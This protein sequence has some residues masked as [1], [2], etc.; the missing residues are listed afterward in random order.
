VSDKVS[1][2]ILTGA[3]FAVYVLA[4]ASCAAA[5]E[6]R[7]GQPVLDGAGLITCVEKR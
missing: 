6:D 1:I 2:W 5:C 3:L 7:G 4:N